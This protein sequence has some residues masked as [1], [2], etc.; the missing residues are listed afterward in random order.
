MEIQ[1]PTFW[2]TTLDVSVTYL[3]VMCSQAQTRRVGRMEFQIS[4]K[5]MKNM[6]K[7]KV[8]LTCNYF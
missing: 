8:I 2:R 7:K 4:Q 1:N 3:R 6:K 5:I